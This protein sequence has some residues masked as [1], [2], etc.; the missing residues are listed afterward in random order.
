M[1]DLF[2]G[3]VLGLATVEVTTAMGRAIEAILAAKHEKSE[4]AQ[5]LA[6][7]PCDYRTNP[8]FSPN[9]SAKK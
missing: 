4:F 6:E 5:F 3:W 2:L 9:E 1:S 8:Q 7:T